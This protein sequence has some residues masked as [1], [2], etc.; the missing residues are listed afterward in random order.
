[1]KLP[2]GD[3]RSSREAVEDVKKMS[4]T[5]AFSWAPLALSSDVCAG[6]AKQ[7]PQHLPAQAAQ[8]QQ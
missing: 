4:N 1:M 5:E 8:L 7:L 3:I 6:A 2:K